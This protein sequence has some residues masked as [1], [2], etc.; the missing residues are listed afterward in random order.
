ML[1]LKLNHAHFDLGFLGF[2][3]G[4]FLGF[5]GLVGGEEH[6]GPFAEKEEVWVF[7]LDQM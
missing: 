4:G 2:L 5:R 1:V 3:F 6:D 7:E